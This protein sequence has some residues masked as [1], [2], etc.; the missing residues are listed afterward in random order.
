MKK[1]DHL[2]ANFYLHACRQVIDKVKILSSELTIFNA[3]NDKRILIVFEEFCK[4]E[5]S[6]ENIT[7]WNAIQEF[8]HQIQTGDNKK[9]QEI[10]KT[11][12]DNFL[13]LVN[14][15]SDLKKNTIAKVTSTG[16]KDATVFDSLEGE[17]VYLMEDTFSRFKNTEKLKKV[18]IQ[19][20]NLKSDLLNEYFALG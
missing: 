20:N 8:K 11:I 16:S 15:T 10:S 1:P 19:T 13:E 6:S 12:C 9:A 5:D 4:E 2:L 18:L 7:L 3:L 17:I 14:I